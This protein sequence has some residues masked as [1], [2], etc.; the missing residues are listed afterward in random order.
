MSFKIVCSDNSIFKSSFESIGD[1]VDEVIMIIDSEGFRINAIDRSHIAFVTLELQPSVFDEFEC[2]EPEKVTID[3]QQF[4][5]I[6]KRM[7]SDDILTLTSEE[8]NF[9]VKLS[10]DAEREFKIRL[11]DVEYETPQP[12]TIEIPCM[13]HVKSDIIKDSITDMDLFAERLYFMIDQDYFIVFTEGE[14]GDGE[15]K[16]LHGEYGINEVVKSSFS[17][18]KLKQMMKS[19]KFS[20]DCEIGLGTDMPLI[21]NFVLPSDDGKLGFLLAPRLEEKE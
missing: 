4:M 6:L 16:Y 14:F 13:I 20:S 1:I 10:G 5:T 9:I 3:T 18:D 21:L 2:E 19:S 12:P 7:K 17:I 15:V 11:I 8:G